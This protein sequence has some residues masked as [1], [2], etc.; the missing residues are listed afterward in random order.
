MNALNLAL[1]QWITAGSQPTPWVLAVAR[2]FALW[3]SWLCAGLIVVALWRHRA[4][5][6]YL[7]VVAAVAG[8]TSLLS[9]AIAVSLNVARP[10]VQG[11][12]PAYIEH[13]RSGSL[14]S[15]HA[16]VMFML[17]LA[18]LLR[19]NLRRL[20]VP[21]L[22][23]AAATGWAR[24][25]VGVHFPLDIVA[26]LLL[27]GSIA[28]ALAAVTWTVHLFAMRSGHA[29]ADGHKTKSLWRPS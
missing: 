18:F 25:Y 6:A 8:L 7:C 4:D 3:G 15:T 14:P 9:H 16:A 20:G 19:P 29:S 24:V 27:G 11:L 21:L 28:C 23:L 17:A 12:A 2:S 1:F 10:F 13:A 22:A 5:R 26:G